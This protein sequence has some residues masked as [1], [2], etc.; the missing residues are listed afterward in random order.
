MQLIAAVVG[1]GTRLLV[2]HHRW[3][4]LHLLVV[5]HRL[6]RLLR[7]RLEVQKLL[8]GVRAH[9]RILVH[10]RAL[11]VHL[12]QL[13]L[14]HSW[15][16]ALVLKAWLRLGAHGPWLVLRL[17][18]GLHHV[19]LAL[20]TNIV[21]LLSLGHIPLLL[22]QHF[23]MVLVGL[24]LLKALRGKLLINLGLVFTYGGKKLVRI[25]LELLRTALH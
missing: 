18:H 1:V 6:L 5:K 14:V 2:V 16:A 11:T 7:L 12:V 10:S 8:V 25:W 3:R 24:L 13:L 15:R 20:P 23:Q 22:S 19:A 21:L 9:R 4:P 17:W